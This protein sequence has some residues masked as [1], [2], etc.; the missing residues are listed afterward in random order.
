MNANYTEA[1]CHQ[2][3]PDVLRGGVLR[4]VK[5]DCLYGLH[6]VRVI[7]KLWQFSDIELAHY[8][9]IILYYFCYHPDAISGVSSRRATFCDKLEHC[10]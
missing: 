9:R 1:Q 5:N 6:G 8:G 2:F 10:L 4:K 7:C 3:I